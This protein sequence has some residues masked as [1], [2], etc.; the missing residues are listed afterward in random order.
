MNFAKLIETAKEK[1][2][3][4][5]KDREMIRVVADPAVDYYII[6]FYGKIYIGHFLNSGFERPMPL[7]YPNAQT[8]DLTSDNERDNMKLQEL[9]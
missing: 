2:N 6:R 4:L 3:M 7:L 8:Y 5:T 9:V 1:S